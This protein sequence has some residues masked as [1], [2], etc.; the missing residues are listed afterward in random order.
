MALQVPVSVYHG[1][2]PGEQQAS[3]SSPAGVNT[4]GGLMGKQRLGEEE[5]RVEIRNVEN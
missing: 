3:V 4:G 5:R 1:A 2:L